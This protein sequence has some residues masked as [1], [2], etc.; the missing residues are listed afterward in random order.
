MTNS[1]H[2]LNYS[3]RLKWF[4]KPVRRK[5]VKVAPDFK[6]EPE[7]RQW[8]VDNADY[9]T[10]IRR[11]K[12]T[13]ERHELPTLDAAYKKAKALADK[14]GAPYLIYAVA[15]AHDTWVMNVKPAEKDYGN[16]QRRSR[17]DT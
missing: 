11:V 2:A 4:V 15:G 6:T 5:Q 16:A 17:E 3:I 8:I 12:R 9:F 14:E 13:Y 10:V 7:R 1:S